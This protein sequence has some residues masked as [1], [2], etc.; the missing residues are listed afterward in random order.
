MNKGN[1]T[2]DECYRIANTI[3][4]Q[5]GS[6]RFSLT[7]G[8]EPLGYGELDGR[9]FLLMKVGKNGRGISL[10]EVSYDEGR[11]LY[12]VRFMRKNGNTMSI[13]ANCSGVFVDML[14]GIFSQYT[15]I[16]VNLNQAA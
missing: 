5:L 12:D 2:Q 11:D 4:L 1:Y 15:G 14:H 9:V 13:A 8:T 7:T 16:E 10:F 6:Q 3:W